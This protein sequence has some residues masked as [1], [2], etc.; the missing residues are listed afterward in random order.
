[1]S[2]SYFPSAPAGSSCKNNTGQTATM[3]FPATLL[4][5]W[6]ASKER[7]TSLESVRVKTCDTCYKKE[8]SVTYM[9]TLK[10]CDFVSHMMDDK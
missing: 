3:A 2:L 1:M 8:V 9:T 4:Q 10:T 5:E 7:T 6:M